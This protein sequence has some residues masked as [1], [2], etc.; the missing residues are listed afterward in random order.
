MSLNIPPPPPPLACHSWIQ[1][2]KYISSYLKPSPFFCCCSFLVNVVQL[3]KMSRG[4]VVYVDNKSWCKIM[5]VCLET[6]ASLWMSPSLQ[7]TFFKGLTEFTAKDWFSQSATWNR[8]KQRW[9][10][11]ITVNGKT[12]GA[13][14][15]NMSVWFTSWEG[16]VCS[17]T[18]VHSTLM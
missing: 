11:N 2:D 13:F 1:S 4:N 10:Q 5:C 14:S 12:D 9:Y 6:N 15:I 7:V 18:R 3:S 16:K 17:R 8:M